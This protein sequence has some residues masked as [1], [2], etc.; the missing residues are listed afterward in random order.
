MAHLYREGDTALRRKA[1]AVNVVL[2]DRCVKMGFP[3]EARVM[4]A[5]DGA[6]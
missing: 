2:Y 4:A 6:C 5:P 1:A 3:P